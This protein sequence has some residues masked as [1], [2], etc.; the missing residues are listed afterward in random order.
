MGS[1]TE[2]RLSRAS[3]ETLSCYPATGFEKEQFPIVFDIACLLPSKTGVW[4][5]FLPSSPRTRLSAERWTFQHQ[6]T[7]KPFST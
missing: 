6:E 4:L 3:Q 2:A 1:Q 5:F 7:G